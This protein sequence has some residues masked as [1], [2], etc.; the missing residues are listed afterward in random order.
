MA[1]AKILPGAGER[2]F[3]VNLD[4]TTPKRGLRGRTRKLGIL[5]KMLNQKR[6]CYI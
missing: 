4:S 3:K 1:I 5:F 6:G 2:G